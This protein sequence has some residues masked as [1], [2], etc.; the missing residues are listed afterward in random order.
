MITTVLK[1]GRYVRTD[2]VTLNDILGSNAAVLQQEQLQQLQTGGCAIPNYWIELSLLDIRIYNHDTSI[3]RFQLPTGQQRL[4]LPVGC[5]LLIKHPSS[6]ATIRPYTAT[7][8]DDVLNG[9]LGINETGSFEILC[10]RYDE[11]GQKESVSTHFLFTKTDHSYRPAGIMSNYLH[12]LKV[13][14]HVGFQFNHLCGGSLGRHLQQSPPPQS[15]DTLTMIAV[16]V[17][18]APMIHALRTLFKQRDHD[19]HENAA[20]IPP[21]R[22]KVV[23]LYGVREVRD[24][25][26][27]ELLEEWRERY[28][29]IF[30]LHYCVGSRWANV[31]MGAKTK[32][33]YVP[34]PLP[35]G[36]SAIAHC[37]SLGWVNED[38]IKAYGYPPSDRTL[39]V[40][41]GLPGVYQKLCGPRTDVQL[42]SDSAL[43]NLGYRSEMVCKL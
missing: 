1:F 31:H 3:F 32:S 21:P 29:D 27:R 4:N 30:S 22:L 34:P 38:K 41:C 39:V 8:D 23:L 35:T 43:Y 9:D 40:V 7:H 12:T 13:G 18:I 14:D 17:G 15:L 37:A 2:D 24:I 10:K 26:M 20:T 36:F 16:G 5:F 25:L 33:D 11:W 28:P 19:V 42:S 6:D